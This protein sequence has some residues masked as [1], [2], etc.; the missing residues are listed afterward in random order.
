MENPHMFNLSLPLAFFL[1]HC[2][3]LLFTAFAASELLGEG[4]WF[5][6]IFSAKWY[7]HWWHYKK[8]KTKSKTYIGHHKYPYWFQIL[9]SISDHYSSLVIGQRWGIY[10][11]RK[12]SPFCSRTCWC[13]CSDCPVLS[14]NYSAAHFE[15]CFCEVGRKMTI[16]S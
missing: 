7:T 1:L 13:I 2:L 11:T 15:S 8:T 16:R 10:S 9:W 4:F 5:Y 6:V 3:C 12:G 14:F